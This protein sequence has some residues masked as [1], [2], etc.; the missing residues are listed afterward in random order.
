MCQVSLVH[1]LRFD[2]QYYHLIVSLQV[3]MA[4]PLGA[5]LMRS[6]ILR[7]AVATALTAHRLSLVAHRPCMVRSLD[8]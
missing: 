5:R 7:G 2:Q 6:L 3:A 8:L 1:L 4:V